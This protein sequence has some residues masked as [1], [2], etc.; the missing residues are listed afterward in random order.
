M[1]LQYMFFVV[2]SFQGK[3]DDYFDFF[4]LTNYYCFA[5]PR[6]NKKFKI[7]IVEIQCEN[8]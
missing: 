7:L 1:F 2:K 4:G 6:F 3:S 8:I 5:I